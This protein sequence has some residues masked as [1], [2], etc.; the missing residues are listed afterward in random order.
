MAV[1]FQPAVRR[2][3]V[4]LAQ[5]G[6]HRADLSGAYWAMVHANHRG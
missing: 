1:G 5:P 3:D 6:G 4:Q 2:L